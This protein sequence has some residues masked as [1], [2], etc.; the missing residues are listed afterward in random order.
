MNYVLEETLDVG[1][2]AECAGD[3]IDLV[4]WPAEAVVRI[5]EAELDGDSVAV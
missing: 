2:S 1:E 4:H 3:C 5:T